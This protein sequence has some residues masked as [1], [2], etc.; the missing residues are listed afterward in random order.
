[1]KVGMEIK[2]ISTKA[3]N[4]II[5]CKIRSLSQVKQIKNLDIKH[6]SI[7]LLDENL[8]V[9]LGR[10]VLH[11][12][13]GVGNKTGGHVGLWNCNGLCSFCIGEEIWMVGGGSIEHGI[14]G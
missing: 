1:M 2:T 5:S 13:K 12:T 14:N 7:K 10:D 4:P 3:Y 6:E 9:S 11:D 8:G